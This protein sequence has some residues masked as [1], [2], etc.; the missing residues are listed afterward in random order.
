MISAIRADAIPGNG[1][2]RMTIQSS[3]TKSHRM[4]TLLEST[5]GTAASA[6]PSQLWSPASGSAGPAVPVVP[7]VP[8]SGPGVVSLMVV[9]ARGPVPGGSGRRAHDGAVR[10]GRWSSR[11]RRAARLRR[12]LVPERGVAGVQQAVGGLRVGLAVELVVQPQ[13]VRVLVGLAVL[14]GLVDVDEHLLAGRHLADPVGHRMPGT[15][16][17]RSTG[18]CGG[19]SG[20]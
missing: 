7:A 8:A 14:R 18:E 5:A 13:D 17:P 15:V 10:S 3:S 9:L 20:S 1:T 19:L 16:D 11:R 4:C 12:R 2:A 6:R